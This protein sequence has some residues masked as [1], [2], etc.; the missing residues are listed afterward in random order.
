MTNFFTGRPHPLI[1]LDIA[2]NHN[3]SVEH[4]K[5]IID[6]VFEVTSQFDFDVA[7]KFQYRDLDSFI[8]QSFKGDWNFKYIK[9]FEETRLSTFEFEQLISYAKS[10]KLLVACTPFDEI[11]V[12]LIEKQDIDI[13]K[14]ASVSLTDWPLLNRISN[15][16]LPVVASTAGSKMAEIDKVASFLSK[17]LKDLAFMHCVASYPTPDYNLQLNRIDELKERYSPI[18]IGYS[19]HENP[20][21]TDAVKLAMAKGVQIL[22]RHVGSKENNNALNSYSSDK[23]N[24][25]EWFNSI[26]TILPMLDYSISNS[27]VNTTELSSLKGLRRGAYAKEN[28]DKGNKFNFQEVYFAIPLQDNQLSANEFSA[29]NDYIAQNI[30]TKNSPIFYEDILI[31]NKQKPIALITESVKSM[32]ES[33]NLAVPKNLRLEISHHYGLEKFFNFGMVMATI[34]NREYCKK[35]LFLRE[36]QTNPEHYHKIKE[37][38]FYCL[39]GELEVVLDGRS[40]ILHPGMNLT[41]PIGAKHLLRTKIGTIVEEIST[42]SIPKDSYYS[43]PAIQKSLHR[44]TFATIWV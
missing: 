44:K 42:K 38:T 34:V 32:I 36:G 43:D 13:L 10:K 35:L 8:H 15:I 14:I 23:S 30:I 25:R 22:E 11:S 3:G 12:D 39:F 2:N 29:Y 28:V 37:E 1:I 4:G 33:A 41:I 27:K 5:R 9:R 18:P 6:D 24:L 17:R 19:T 7:V 16:T 21:N 26:N 40:H 31:E 20:S